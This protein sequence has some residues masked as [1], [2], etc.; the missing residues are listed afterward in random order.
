MFIK[1]LIEIEIKEQETSFF[2]LLS[3]ATRITSS[4]KIEYTHC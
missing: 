1:N 3:K 4:K 2:S